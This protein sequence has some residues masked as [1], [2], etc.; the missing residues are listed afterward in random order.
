MGGDVALWV[1]MWCYV[2]GVGVT[3]DDEFKAA[4]QTGQSCLSWASRR[5]GHGQ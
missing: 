5:I 1:E 3:V 2:C 4:A